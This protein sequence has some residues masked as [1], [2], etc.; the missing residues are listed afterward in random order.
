MAEDTQELKIVKGAFK[1]V[2]PV[3]GSHEHPAGTVV[4]TP[5][6]TH[7]RVEHGGERWVWNEV[8]PDTE[9]NKQTADQR[10]V[11]RDALKARLA[12]LGEDA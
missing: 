8:V 7:Y 4:Q 10:R 6:G 2:L 12:E 11:E 5:E 9:A 1:R 3:A